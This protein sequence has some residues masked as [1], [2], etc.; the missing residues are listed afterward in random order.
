MTKRSNSRSA[1]TVDSGKPV[2]RTGLPSSVLAGL[3]ALMALAVYGF[4]IWSNF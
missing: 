2:R 4:F 1:Q 3:L